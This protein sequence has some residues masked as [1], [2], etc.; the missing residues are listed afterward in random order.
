MT[1][2]SDRKIPPFI[3][4]LPKKTVLLQTNYFSV[5]T[6]YLFSLLYNQS[7]GDAY[8]RNLRRCA[9]HRKFFYNIFSAA[10]NSKAVKKRR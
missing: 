3:I 5:L 6:Y 8:D 1:V 9:F 10:C 2:I 7:S 4:L